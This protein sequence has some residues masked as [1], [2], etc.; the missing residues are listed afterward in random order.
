MYIT[1]PRITS[2]RK[3]DKQGYIAENN[4]YYEEEFTSRCQEIENMKLQNGEIARFYC[5]SKKSDDTFFIKVS[6]GEELEKDKRPY[7]NYEVY[8]VYPVSAKKS[9]NAAHQLMEVA[10]KKQTSILLSS[11]EEFP[12]NMCIFGKFIPKPLREKLIFSPDDTVSLGIIPVKEGIPNESADRYI[13]EYCSSPE[14]YFRKFDEVIKKHYAKGGYGDNVYDE[15]R[16]C[17]KSFEK[18]CETCDNVYSSKPSDDTI[19]YKIPKDAP[20]PRKPEWYPDISCLGNKL[21]VLSRI[22]IAYNFSDIVM[23]TKIWNDEDACKIAE[24]TSILKKE[25][26]TTE[27][28]LKLL[29]YIRPSM[30]SKRE[31][32]FESLKNMLAGKSEDTSALALMCFYTKDFPYRKNDFTKQGADPFKEIL[33]F[34]RKEKPDSVA[35]KTLIKKVRR[36]NAGLLHTLKYKIF[37]R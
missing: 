25:C 35:K 33:K 15:F 12:E 26:R 3:T 7:N 37:L 34:Y 28:R 18:P 13:K 8:K 14:T 5:F 23:N 1:G 22:N 10:L 11:I 36:S 20:R 21:Y 30:N 9:D 4:I 29:E 27:E 19:E 17:M 2:R 6:R 31:Y 24:F 32:L 16:K